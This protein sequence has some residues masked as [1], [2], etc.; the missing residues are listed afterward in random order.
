M[1]RYHTSILSLTAFALAVFCSEGCTPEPGKNF[2]ND[3]DTNTF[4]PTAKYVGP[5]VTELD[6]GDLGPDETVDERTIFT[7][8]GDY[9]VKEEFDGNAD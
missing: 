5:C 3:T 2:Q 9:V 4:V 8:D 1:K 7:Y 6:R